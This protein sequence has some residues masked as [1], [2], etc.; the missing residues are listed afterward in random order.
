MSQHSAL[1][2]KI[3]ECIFVFFSEYQKL[4]DNLYG[5]TGKI[6][7]QQAANLIEEHA[8][9]RGDRVATYVNEG[10]LLVALVSPLM[11]RANLYLPSAAELVFIDGSGSCDT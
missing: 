4:I 6:N 5:P 8:K 2:L 9:K 1:Y 7:P 10:N 3:N 11:L